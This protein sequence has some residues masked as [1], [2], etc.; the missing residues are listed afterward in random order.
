MCHNIFKP[1]CWL[2]GFY[3]P[4]E[5]ILLTFPGEKVSTK[6]EHFSLDGVLQPTMS[7]DRGRVTVF[8]A[9]QKHSIVLTQSSASYLAQW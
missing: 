2:M 3:I 5:G 9:Q 8:F 1:T 7:R 6:L 4:K